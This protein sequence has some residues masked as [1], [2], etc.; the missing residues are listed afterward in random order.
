MHIHLYIYILTN[1]FQGFKLESVLVSPAQ[2]KGY[3]DSQ[4]SQRQRAKE[5]WCLLCLLSILQGEKRN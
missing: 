1:I 4:E 3:N 5:F 2:K